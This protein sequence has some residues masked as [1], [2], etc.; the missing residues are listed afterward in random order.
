MNQISATEQTFDRVKKVVME[1]LRL[2]DSDEITPKANV[3]DDLG[4]DSLDMVDVIQ[5]LEDE[6]SLSIP[7]EALPKGEPITIQ[8]ITGY[9]EGELAKAE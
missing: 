3:I 9:I 8:R 4:A 2:K 6:F 7:D 1:R 5:G